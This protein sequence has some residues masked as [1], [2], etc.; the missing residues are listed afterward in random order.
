MKKKWLTIVPAV[1]LTFTPLYFQ[2]VEASN[3]HPAS[4]TEQSNSE[5]PEKLEPIL[6]I[7][8]EHQPT[9]KVDSVGLEVE[10]V[11]VKLNHFGFETD[12]DG[13]FG[14]KTEQQVMN[15]QKEHELMID[16]IVGEEAWTTLLAEERQ[17]MFTV[18]YA[19]FL[20]EEEL[21]NDDLIFSSNGELYVDK[22]G[23]T[24]YNLKASS[25]SMIEDGGTGTVGFYN[26]Y[27]DGEVILS[28]PMSK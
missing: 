23:R 1:A 5:V 3:D 14:S 9:L 11:Q 28:E 16:G 10:L 4:Q 8:P 21:N 13:I 7:A 6:D 17:D 18:D 15:F 25:K 27:S 20:A 12:V 24:F 2:Q 19:I 22:E 26:V